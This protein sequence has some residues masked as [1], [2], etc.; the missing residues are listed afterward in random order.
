MPDSVATHAA[1]VAPRTCP[2]LS[3]TSAGVFWRDSLGREFD[4]L[5]EKR[6]SPGEAALK[7]NRSSEWVLR[8][9][10]DNQL[11]PHVYFTQRTVELWQCAIDDYLI[12]TIRKDDH[13]GA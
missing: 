1:S 8:R 10:R 9:I 7:M 11:Y 5:R 2:G 4:L 13:A 3:V 12:R 6:L